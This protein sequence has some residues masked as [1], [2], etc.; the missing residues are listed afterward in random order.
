MRVAEQDIAI[1][2]LAEK[3]GT[4]KSFEGLEVNRIILK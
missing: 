3:S 4:K 2:M 1:Q